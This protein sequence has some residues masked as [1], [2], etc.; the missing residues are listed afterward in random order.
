M[1]C[2]Q[3][4]DAS[5]PLQ[6][7]QGS[8]RKQPLPSSQH[9][10][11]ED[12]LF[13]MVGNT[14]TNGLVLGFTPN[15]FIPI[16]SRIAIPRYCHALLQTPALGFITGGVDDLEANLSAKATID[17]Q[18]LEGTISRKFLRVN[19]AKLLVDPEN[20]F[21]VLPDMINARYAHCAIQLNQTLFVIGDRQYGSDENGLLSACEGFDFGSKK[22]KA[23][24]SMQFPRAA[25]TVALYGEHIYV[26]GGYSGSNNRTR[27]IESYSPGD[28]SWR[29]LPYALH[30]G[31]EGALAVKKPNS[32][33]SLL[34]LGG[35]TNFGK[36]NRVVE[37]NLDKA[38][39][40]G[41]G[42]TVEL[43]SFHKG[44]VVKGEVVL[45]G[46]GCERIEYYSI[47]EQRSSLASEPSYL[48]YC[49]MKELNAFSQFHS[50]INLKFA[51]K[52]EGL[53]LFDNRV[54]IFGHAF[55]PFAKVVNTDNFVV[56][57][58][59]QSLMH[60]FY[61]FTSMQSPIPAV[62]KVNKE[63]CFVLG[64]INPD[65]SEV[66]NTVYSFNLL[67]NEIKALD[68]ML[69]PRYAFSAVVL[70][71]YLYAIGGRKLGDDEMA[72]MNQCE[73]FSF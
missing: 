11:P 63:H 25:A 14:A 54:C 43:R 7:G 22:W 67:D 23:I 46:G 27:A 21:E 58:E 41:Y 24:P 68:P 59:G 16:P 36:S 49:T 48:E 42:G 26:F 34:L 65:L 45:V 13:T 29:R 33:S 51:K 44:A 47:M 3:S 72:I 55:E 35:K 73:R 39:V 28:S 9:H 1:G 66:T 64:G 4:G 57:S 69:T 15:A 71:S 31:F 70:G 52:N 53:P 17:S 40:S 60:S 10:S 6:K 5:D 2:S 20:S 62:V 8:P 56:I 37:V 19:M 18:I 38:A 32:E 12:F 50:Q 61:Q 30:E